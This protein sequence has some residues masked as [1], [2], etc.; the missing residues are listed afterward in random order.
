MTAWVKYIL[1]CEAKIIGNM[2][3]GVGS[4]GWTCHFAYKRRNTYLG[5]VRLLNETELLYYWDSV[6]LILESLNYG[7]K[8]QAAKKSVEEAFACTDILFEDLPE[9]EYE[10]KTGFSCI[11]LAFD[12]VS[13]LPQGVINREIQEKN[14]RLPEK[15]SKVCGIGIL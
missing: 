15:Y 10:I 2:L 4:Y 11:L 1:M 12:A 14:L 13:E 9:D 6:M 5:G 3:R 8:I 7:S